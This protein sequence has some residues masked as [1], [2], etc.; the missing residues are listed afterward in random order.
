MDL[1]HH[2]TSCAGCLI[3]RPLSL[4][5]Q[6]FYYNK[7]HPVGWLLFFLFRLLS[8]SDLLKSDGLTLLYGF[9]FR[10][11][12]IRCYSYE[13]FV[14][15]YQRTGVVLVESKN[16]ITHASE[17]DDVVSRR[18]PVSRAVVLVALSLTRSTLT[19]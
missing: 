11:I 8:A 15:L 7:N 14:T 1:N 3:I 12:G 19:S 10:L 9:D 6:Q 5:S 16:P 18:D 2:L 17:C 4:S 13:A